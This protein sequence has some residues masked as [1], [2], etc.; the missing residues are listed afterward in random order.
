MNILKF[1]RIPYLSIFMA[2]L[3]LFV[4]C[5]Q[6]DAPE[7][8]QNKF[9]YSSFNNFKSSSYFDDIVKNVKSRFS[10]S[11]ESTNQI[12]LDE[13]NA[14]LGTNIE[15]PNDALQLSIEM[16]PT[17]IL[18]IAKNNSWL[19]QED[20][21]ITNEFIEDME[22][23]GFDIAV[24]NYESNILA[25]NLSNEEFAKKNL[26]I[27]MV[28]SMEFKYPDLYDNNESAQAKSW[29]KCAAASIALASAIA[30]TLSCVTI[31]ACALAMVLVYAASNS[32][33]DNCLE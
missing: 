28:K 3:I 33:A 2:S 20:V 27:N 32:F 26:F 4:S 16:N 21:I 25:V 6:Y 19:T 5:E 24:E 15:I 13:V 11:K 10:K 14:Q 8:I 30:G 12:V 17:D 31:A 18:T 7:Q 29:L 23:K 1:L 22:S 9:D